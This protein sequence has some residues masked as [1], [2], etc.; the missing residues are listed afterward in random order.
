MRIT[1]ETFL[2]NIENHKMVE[3]A[4]S[5]N[6]LFFKFFNPKSS[7]CY[8]DIIV[9]KDHLLIRG[10]CGSFL[11][12]RSCPSMLHF[13]NSEEIQPGYWAEKLIAEDYQGLKEYC[14][15]AAKESIL[16]CF[17]E[18][19]CDWEEKDKEELL[20]RIEDDILFY[21]YDKYQLIAELRNFESYCDIFVDFFLD[22]S[23]EK[24]TDRYVWSCYAVNYA[25]K[26]I[27]N[28]L[29]NKNF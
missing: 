5:E 10:D 27:L 11:F 28:Y 7:Y 26:K 8:F 18:Y 9:W 1:K 25:C 29:E 2:K 3:V 14:P 15:E 19:T 23:F 16:K 13:F 6:I 21:V 20:D 17:E 24:F 22:Y 4:A 12:C